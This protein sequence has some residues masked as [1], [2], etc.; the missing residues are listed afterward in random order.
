[1]IE[2]CSKNL[3][4]RIA[5]IKAGE[6]GPALELGN[7]LHGRL[8]AYAR[9]L[10]PG[11]FE[12][13]FERLSLRWLRLERYGIK[14]GVFTKPEYAEESR[15]ALS[16]S[17]EDCEWKVSL[18]DDLLVQIEL[19]LSMTEGKC[20]TNKTFT[21]NAGRDFCFTRAGGKPPQ[22]SELSSGERRTLLLFYEPPFNAPPDS[23]VMI[24][25]PETSLHVAWQPEFIRDL[26]KIIDL[27]ELT[28][29]TGKTTRRLAK[30]KK[31]PGIAQT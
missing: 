6:D 31:H 10:P 26:K 25:D 23:L 12:E 28:H 9:P 11:V 4:E 15:R 30:E 29:V 24:D 5:R 7:T 8:L 20:L 27:Y 3:V 22:V 16:L 19:F 17:L 1:M 13:R 14:P 21:V 2:V 18:Y